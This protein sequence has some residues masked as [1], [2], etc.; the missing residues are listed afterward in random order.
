[1]SEQ[2]E[3]SNNINFYS[4]IEKTLELFKCIFLHFYV[5]QYL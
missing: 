3:F 1:M 2:N 4:V 5:T